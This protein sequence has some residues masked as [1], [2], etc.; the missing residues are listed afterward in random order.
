MLPFCRVHSY[1]TEA[2]AR[3][4]ELPAPAVRRQSKDS[5]LLANKRHKERRWDKMRLL[6]EVPP[7]VCAML[8][9][10]SYTSAHRNHNGEK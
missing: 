7:R 3:T 5:M 8:H 2:H 9:S 6:F 10:H 4:A 1:H